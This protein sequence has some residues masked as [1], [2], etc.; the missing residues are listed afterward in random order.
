[1]YAKITR[2]NLQVHRG[3]VACIATSFELDGS[4]IESQCE[5]RFSAPGQTEIAADPASYKMGIVIVALSTHL[6]LL[7]RSKKE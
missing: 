6:H 4:L 7:A 1:M 2:T 3:T 5:A